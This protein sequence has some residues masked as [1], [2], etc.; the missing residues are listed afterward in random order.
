[1]PSIAYLIDF[2]RLW[3]NCGCYY[4]VGRSWRA[5]RVG[6]KRIWWSSLNGASSLLTS[7]RY[8]SRALTMASIECKQSTARSSSHG[9]GMF[10]SSPPQFHRASSRLISASCA[11]RAATWSS[12]AL[13]PVPFPS[14]HTRE[15]RK[16]ERDGAIVIG[17]YVRLALDFIPYST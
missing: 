7:W 12:S 5:T 2:M 14:S 6:M 3:M 8:S 13:L 15:G 11:V 9:E 1:M 10:L 16:G 17:K 4:M